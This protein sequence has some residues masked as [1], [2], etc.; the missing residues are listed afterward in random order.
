MRPA[1][2]ESYETVPQRP[3]EASLSYNMCIWKNTENRA[4]E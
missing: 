4:E 3:A 1:Y 2:A